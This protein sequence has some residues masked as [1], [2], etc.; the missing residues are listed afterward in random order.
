[1]LRVLHVAATNLAGIPGEFVAG[2]RERGNESKLLTFGPSPYGFDDGICLH[3]PWFGSPPFLTLKKAFGAG[4]RVDPEDQDGGVKVWKPGSFFEG[5]VIGLR[6]NLWER[7]ARSA[8]TRYRFWDYDLLHLDGGICFTYRPH[9]LR[10][11]LKKGRR[12]VVFYYGSDLRVRGR[13]PGVEEVA[14]LKLTCEFDLLE[15]HP[16]LRFLPQPFD[17]GR[18]APREKENAVLRVC[19]SPTNRAAKGS[20][21]IIPIVRKLEK[22]FPVELVLIESRP[23]QEALAIKAGCDLA[24]EQVGNRAGTGYGMNSIETLALGI[25]TLTELTEAYVRFIPDHPFI[26]VTRKT[27]EE[28]LVQTIRDPDLRCRKAREGRDWVLKTHGRKAVMERL[29]GMYRE[30]GIQE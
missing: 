3:Y 11:L 10:E 21:T 18:F 26:P 17:E 16:G 1:M 13:L 23:H 2:H 25:P 7:R 30:A 24:V 15:R 29:Y 12:F 6:D 20:E 27:L 22:S 5:L 19:H 14:S 28:V 4:R 9:L 8:L